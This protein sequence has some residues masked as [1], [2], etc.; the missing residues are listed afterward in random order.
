MTAES[1]DY[2]KQISELECSLEDMQLTMQEADRAVASLESKITARRA[3]NP[4]EPIPFELFSDFCHD[5]TEKC[6]MAMETVRFQQRK[7][8]IEMKVKQELVAEKQQIA[9]SD[10]IVVDHEALV[11]QQ[12]DNE[13][14]LR[15]VSKTNYELKL[16]G[17]VVKR[18]TTREKIKLA[19]TMQ[20]YG[21][22]GE[23]CC[24]LERNLRQLEEK[25]ERTEMD[26]TE[27]EVINDE[28]RRKAEQYR[29]PNVL[30][31]ARKIDE[32]ERAEREI[33]GTVKNKLAEMGEKGKQ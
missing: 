14:E 10:S 9:G 4:L 20:Q 5:W 19:E 13:I 16:M 25:I 15:N 22:I 8:A 17:G 1:T 33:V 11:I 24:R 2:G 12:K 23:D 7:A 30:E 32:L 29:A 3:R 28:L 27:L 18:D 31:I 6:K 21:Q 26:I